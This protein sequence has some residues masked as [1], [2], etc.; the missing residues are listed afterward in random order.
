M[1][2]IKPDADLV[3]LVIQTVLNHSYYN[4]FVSYADQNKCEPIIRDIIAEAERR[5]REKC[6][7]IAE[8]RYKPGRPQMP[9]VI[10]DAI[11]ARGSETEGGK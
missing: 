6:A 7:K 10:A 8:S 5:E 4:G 9:L 1:S 3:E 11:R 2:E